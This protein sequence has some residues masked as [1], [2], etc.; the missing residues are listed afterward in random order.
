M[1]TGAMTAL[2]TPF[3]GGRVDSRALER[4]V[5]QQIEGGING[6]VPCGTT[7]ESATLSHEEHTEVVRL[8]VKAARGRVPVIAGTGS[9]STAEAVRLTREAKEV[10]ADGALLISPYY[11][12]PTQDGIVQHYEEVARAVDLP[13]IVYNIPARTGS[14]LEV[15]TLARLGRSPNIVGVKDATGSLDHILDTVHA[16]GATL[17]VISGEDALTLPTIAVGGQGVITAVGNVVPGEMAELAAAC[18]EGRLRDAQAAQLRLLP[19]I[20]ACFLETN[21]IPVKTACAMLGRCKEEFRLPMTPMSEANRVKLHNA[22]KTH[23]LLR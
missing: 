20:R 1:F 14:K 12:R 5:E 11:N 10:G 18:L 23:G 15:P 8:T 13:L 2:I 6:L 22:L 19:L 16:C 4:L 17:A 3:D 21:P 9:N 7:G